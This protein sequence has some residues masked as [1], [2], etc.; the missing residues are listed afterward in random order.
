M[1]VTTKKERILTLLN[2]GII[3]Q[4]EALELLEQLT[5][6]EAAVVDQAPRVDPMV[7]PVVAQEAQDFQQEAQTS[8]QEPE[9]KEYSSDALGSLFKSITE[10]TKVVYDKVAKAI[11]DNVDFENGMPKLKFVTRDM[12]YEFDA[13]DDLEIDSVSGDVTINVIDGDKAIVDADYKI[14]GVSAE[15]L[16]AYMAERVTAAVANNKLSLLSKGNRIAVDYTI[17]LP[18]KTYHNFLLNVTNGDI[19]MAGVEVGSLVANQV[20]GDLDTEAVIV[21]GVANITGKNGDV[22]VKDGAMKDLSI[23]TVNGDTILSATYE[24]AVLNAVN[25]DA[26][27]TMMDLKPRN[28]KVDNVN[29]DIKVSMPQNLGLIGQVKTLFGTYK[30]RLHL[31]APLEVT[32]SG[33]VVSRT[34][35]E[36]LS[37]E[38]NTKTGSIWLKDNSAVGPED[39]A[40]GSFTQ[41]VTAAADQLSKTLTDIFSTAKAEMKDA[42]DEAKAEMADKQVT[43]EAPVEPEAPEVPKEGES[44][45]QQ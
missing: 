26:K 20:N 23:K 16:D 40:Q 27:V 10:K 41:E 29:G 30:T 34:G 24:S 12:H 14:Y 18:R 25:G 22:S 5:P 19:E 45:E 38:L 21:A 42:M 3:T 35:D 7:D 43:P 11:D 1:A 33:A 36:M 44:H 4:D 15:E 31:P 6:E 28:L 2:N 37:I 39:E 13:F 8:T 17:Q 9:F 32:K